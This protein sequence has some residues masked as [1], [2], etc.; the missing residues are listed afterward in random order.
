MADASGISPKETM[1]FL[2]RQSGGRQNVGIIPMDYKNYLRSK[3]TRRME[4]GDTGD[5]DYFGDV[6]SFDTTHRKNKDGRPFAMFVG[7]NNH[8]QTIIFGAA[9]LY[10]ETA[11]TFMWLFDTFAETMF[12][13]KPKSI[14][15]DQDAAM[16]KALA[17]Q[18]PESCHRLCIWHMFQN[19]AKHLSHEFHKFNDFTKDFTKC[20][21]DYEDEVEFTDAWKNMLAKYN[22]QNNDWLEGLFSLREKWALVYGRDTFCAEMTITQRSESMNSVLKKYISYKYD[23]V[24]FFEHFERMVDARRYHELTMD[25]K[26]SQSYPA[27]TLPVKILKHAAAIYTPAVFELFQKELC[28]AHDCAVTIISESDTMSKYAITPHGK[29]YHRTV[30]FD[31]LDNNVSCSCR[32]FEFAGYLCSHALKVLSEKNIKIIPTQYILKR[33][34]KDVKS[35]S[36]TGGSNSVGTNDRKVD[37]VRL[38]RE[39]CRLHI[40]L[41]T[42]AS[43][44]E[45]A[46]KIALLALSNTLKE[47]DAK[48]RGLKVQEDLENQNISPAIDKEINLNA[49]FN[50]DNYNVRVIK[51]RTKTTIDT[52]SV[53]PKN[54]LEK[55]VNSKKKRI[56]K[57][58]ESQ[59]NEEIVPAF[60]FQSQMMSQVPNALVRSISMASTD[61]VPAPRPPYVMPQYHTGGYV[62]FSGYQQRP[63][64][65]SYQQRPNFSSYQQRPI[66][67]GYQQ[68]P[69]ALV[70]VLQEH[71]QLQGGQ[72]LYNSHPQ[73]YAWGLHYGRISGE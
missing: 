5:Y 29:E 36:I 17:S 45:E 16:A 4:T 38:Y 18:W 60:D 65:S 28:R 23:L 70:G 40:Q 30:I 37:T 22:L 10:D 25:F 55:A 43:E 11:E 8:R 59:S 42:R 71:T 12:G 67:G 57:T 48:L 62:P 6:V 61:T 24:L 50:V 51:I 19:A 69:N 14:F 15:T 58:M 26:A 1:E 35:G 52:S 47:V 20:V 73:D 44:S 49:S 7:V 21:Y 72:H 9:L 66:L 68:C 3:R 56:S 46:H 39:L 33:W 64:L 54:V 34:T 2:S 32:K 41:A 31:S 53:R 27:M 13:K 63:N